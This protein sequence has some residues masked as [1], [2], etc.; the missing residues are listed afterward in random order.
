MQIENIQKRLFIFLSV[1]IIF[2]IPA[3]WF[4][5][6]QIEDFFYASR[7]AN[8]LEVVFMDVGQGDASLI[9]TPYNQNILIDGGPDNAILS[10]LSRE[11]PWWDKTIDLMILTHPHSDHVSGLIEVLKRY[12]VKKILYTGV[13]HNSPS[14]LA[15]LRLVQEKNVPIV[16]ID[17]P[18]TI[19]FG[20]DLFMD[21]LY[22]NKSFLNKEVDNLNN[23]SIV[24]NLHYQ[25]NLFLFTGDIENETERELLASGSLGKI[26]VL[27]IAH[28]GSNTSSI[29]EFLDVTKPQYAIISVGENNTFGHPNRNVLKRLEKNGVEVFRTDQNGFARF[30]SDGSRIMVDK[31]K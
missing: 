24:A 8:E 5:Y 22:P 16:I 20:K 14:Y 28:H 29:Q 26:N 15:W 25:N 2:T 10:G 19:Y 23:T 21:I 7:A 18:Q 11:M 30:I 31:E 4:S 3:F 17:R 9:K 6:P 27:K 13:L 12:D 1:L